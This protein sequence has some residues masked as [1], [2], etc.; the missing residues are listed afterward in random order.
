MLHKRA[1]QHNLDHGREREREG[2]ECVI[3]YF[4]IVMLLCIDSIFILLWHFVMFLVLI[5]D[6]R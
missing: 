6:Q 5:R 1:V 2:R 4:Y 3:G